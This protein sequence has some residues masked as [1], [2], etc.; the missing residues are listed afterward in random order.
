M[1]NAPFCACGER[2][3]GIGRLRIWIR[4]VLVILLATFEVTHAMA[5]PPQKTI[6]KQQATEIARKTIADLKSGTEFVIL[7]DKTVEK[8]FGWVFIYTPKKFMETK[9]RKY[10]VPGNGP[11]VVNR[12]DGSTRFLSTAAPPAKAIEEY[13]RTWRSSQNAK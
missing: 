1:L 5:F 9:D 12:S 11:L 13:E 7:E 6:T 3:P 8:D 4:F 10:L 2:P